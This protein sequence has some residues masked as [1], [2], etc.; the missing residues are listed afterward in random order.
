MDEPVLD[1]SS[2]SGYQKPGST[3]KRKT[4]DDDDD[5]AID[6][7]IDNMTRSNRQKSQWKKKRG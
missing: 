3:V 2:L 6:E 1:F 7:E 5:D 4:F